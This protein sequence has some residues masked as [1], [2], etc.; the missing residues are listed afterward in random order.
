MSQYPPDTVVR[1][2]EPGQTGSPIETIDAISAGKRP[3]SLNPLQFP[4]SLQESE[5]AVNTVIGSE[6]AY[7]ARM[8][9]RETGWAHPRPG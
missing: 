1:F 9:P 2:P 4:H 6:I 7:S 5:Y 3:S 8:V